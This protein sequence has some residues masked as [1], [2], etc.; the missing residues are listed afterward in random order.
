MNL[1]GEHRV[2][3]RIGFKTFFGQWCYKKKVVAWYRV[4][5]TQALLMKLLLFSLCV[6]VLLHIFKKTSIHMQPTKVFVL[7]VLIY[8]ASKNRSD[9]N[10]TKPMVLMSYSE[11]G[12]EYIKEL[13]Q[14]IK[15]NKA[16][17]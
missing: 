11:R 14:M 16:Y 4:G 7:Y 10:K 5:A 15:H 8:V 17:F 1:R 3:A 9:A 6:K 2:F 12:E 13:N